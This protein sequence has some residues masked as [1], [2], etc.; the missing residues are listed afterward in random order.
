[1]PSDPRILTLDVGT[2]SAR[3][4]VYDAG[5]GRLAWGAEVRRYAPTL[6][7]DGGGT[8]DPEALFQVV[9]DLIDS[10]L[11]QAR[12]RAEELVC[13]ASAAFWHSLL[14][15]D[16]SGEP[17][18]PVYLWMD[19]R[20][21]QAAARLRAELD[22]RQ[23]HARTGCVLHASYL[24][25]KLR[26]VRDD[27]PQTAGRV[28][29]WVSFSE[30]LLKRLLGEAPISV[31][32]A[33]G[34][35]LFD[36]HRCDW[37]DEVLSACGAHRGQ[38][39]RL[40]GEGE[41]LG[42]LRAPWRERWPQL[43][44]V[45]WLP[46]LGDGAASN[47]GAGCTTAMRAAL[48]VGTS[49]ALRVL[50]RTERVVIPW[51][52]WGYRLDRERVCLG[53]ALNDGGNL[54]AWLKSTLRLPEGGELDRALSQLPSDGHGLTLLPLWGGERSPSWA[55]DAHGAILGLGFH[56]SALEIA[57]AAL[58]GVALRCMELE[59]RLREAVPGI[60]QVVATGGGL[61]ASPAWLQIMADALGRELIAS[62]EREASSRGAALFALERLGL[63]PGG[64]DAVPPPDGARY[65]VDPQRHQR[66]RAAGER[67]R[68]LYRQVI[69]PR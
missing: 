60:E 35:G 32:M 68:V 44:R 18:T 59:L 67:Q 64:L 37:D 55:G 63:L 3:T 43:A 26:W 36:Q 28:R 17:C 23:V 29:R 15:L 6:T 16:A 41:M 52:V 38:L 62:A 65:A 45:P 30:F 57:R 1:M 48:M 49:V 56:T 25:A 54:F 58:E 10:T 13:V 34:T 69:E 19:N 5:G 4:A 12:A 9:T 20:A 21:H 66:Y 31:S 51:G 47:V 40:A 46:C 22:E 50:W 53:G 33:S 7:A 27:Q 61:L 39:P 14:G 42:G 11:L 24:P 2:S 8:L